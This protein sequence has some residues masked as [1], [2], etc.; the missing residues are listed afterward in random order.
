MITHVPIIWELTSKLHRTSVTQGF[1]AGLVLC[2]LG[3]SVRYFLWTSQLHT[4]I[5]SEPR[6]QLHT[7][8]HTCYTKELFPNYLCNHFGCHSAWAEMSL[9]YPHR[10]FSPNRKT[11]VVSKIITPENLFFSKLIRR[12][13]IYYAGNSL[14][15]IIFAELIMRGSSVSHYVDRLFWG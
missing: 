7:H 13:V 14:P 5:P 9:T 6:F 8:T 2:N 1:L 11:T 4:R 3:A 10:H 12:G 15:Q